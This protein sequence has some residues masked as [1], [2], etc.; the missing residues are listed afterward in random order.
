MRKVNIY[1]YRVRIPD[2]L[3]ARNIFCASSNNSTYTY[4]TIYLH[5]ITCNHM[6][7]YSNENYSGNDTLYSLINDEIYIPMVV[8]IL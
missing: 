1:T 6:C 5:N 2:V 4:Y 3:L 8:S 7:A